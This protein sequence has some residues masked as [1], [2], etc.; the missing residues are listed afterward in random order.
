[1]TPYLQDIQEQYEGSIPWDFFRD[2]NIL[3][4]GATGL[5]GS[6]LVD[7]LINHPER[8]WKVY[9]MGRNKER[10]DRLFQPYLSDQGFEFIQGD[11]EKPLQGDVPFHYIIHAASNGSPNFFTQKPVEVIKAN[12]YGVANLMEYGMSHQMKRFLYVSSGEVYGNNDVLSLTENDYGYIDIIHP[13]SCYPSAKRTAET[14]TICYGKEYGMD[15][16]IAR[17]C[18]TYG[19]HFTENDNRAYAQFIRNILN[20]EDIHLKSAG[21]QYRSW[22]YVVDCVSALLHILCKGKNG[23][24]YNVADNHSNVTIKELAEMIAKEGGRRVISQQPTEEEIAGF[25][26]IKRAVFDTS[27]LTL[28]GWNPHHSLQVNIKHTIGTLLHERG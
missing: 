4:T 1:M 21:L 12:I 11:I 15:V 9:A 20:H 19:P 27:K 8:T 25:T 17:P 13:R 7:I 2:C 28:L 23:E 10:A 22:C 18:H 14:L 5:I 6:C 24:A 16:V 26:M 3:V